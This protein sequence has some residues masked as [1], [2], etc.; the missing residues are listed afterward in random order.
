MIIILFI[1]IFS[2]FKALT[3]I[4]NGL[5]CWSCSGSSLCNSPFFNPSFNVVTCSGNQVACFVKSFKTQIIQVSSKKSFLFFYLKK[6]IQTSPSEY[7]NR[8]CASSSECL[9]YSS[10]CSS[11]LCNHSISSMRMMTSLIQK[12][13]LALTLMILYLV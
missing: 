3:N 11:F 6:D 4:S 12:A 13:G 10:C 2:L 8:G 1:Y 9:S 7:V 5:M